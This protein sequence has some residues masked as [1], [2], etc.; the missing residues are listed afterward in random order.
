[1]FLAG[2][3]LRIGIIGTDNTHAHAAAGFLNGWRRDVPIPSEWKH[4]PL[5]AMHLWAATLR[6]LENRAGSGV[7]SAVARVSRIWG[8]DPGEAEVIARGCD[9]PA[10]CAR[11]EDVVEDVDGVLVLSEDP[12]THWPY[13]RRALAAGLPC[14]VD[15]PLAGSMA[16]VRAIAS[17]AAE[18]GAPWF[19]GS[20][21]R[22]SSELRRARD[23]IAANGHTHVLVQSGGGPALYTPHVIE[24]ANL[25]MGREIHAVHAR[26]APNRAAFLL[27][28][29]DGRSALLDLI[30]ANVLP[31]VLV[32]ATG[33]GEATRVE[34]RRVYEA[35][36]AMVDA[37]AEMCRTGVSPVDPEESVALIELHFRLLDALRR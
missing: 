7:P 6:E 32:T 1:V 10:V 14:F 33:N 13:V 23:E 34:V 36:H 21:L 8:A 19:G 29:T 3:M 12:A 17:T 9:I 11:P 35:I 16:D 2:E 31:P 37:F 20:A 30:E 28:Y 18:H 5:P 27:E 22:F 26:S 15:K 4:G 25:L 24:V